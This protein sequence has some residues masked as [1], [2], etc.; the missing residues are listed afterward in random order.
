MRILLVEDHPTM[1]F[2]LRTLIEARASDEVVGEAAGYEEALDLAREQKLDLVLL[3]LRLDTGQSGIELLPEL[4]S[5][6]PPPLVLVCSAHNDTERILA[7]RLSGADGFVHKGTDTAR[8]LDAI[9]QVQRW[10]PAW[11][12][13]LSDR[14][15]S[16]E[17]FDHERLSLTPREVEVF[18]LL[19]L[20]L[21]NAEIAARLKIS[22][23]TVKTYVANILGKLNLE[24][25][26]DL[27]SAPRRNPENER[28]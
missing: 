2:A 6:D 18:D 16:C 7:C 19:I 22:S 5:L 15:E 11:L 25:R 8:I 4:K 10:Q 1:R 12:L 20:R 13:G 9:E 17:G 14:E 21:T 27:T 26:R 28:R 24:S 3:D 23:L